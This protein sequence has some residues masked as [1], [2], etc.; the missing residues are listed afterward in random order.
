MYQAIYGGNAGCLAALGTTSCS[1]TTPRVIPAN[2]NASADTQVFL[3]QTWARPDMVFPHLSTVADANYPTVPDGRP[4][5][6]TSNPAFPNGFA[7]TLYYEAEGLAGMTADLRAAFAAKAQANPGFAGVIPVGDAF[8]RAVDQGVAQGDGFYGPDGT[9]AAALPQ[10][11]INL[12]WD[13]YLHASKHGS[14]L[15]ALVIFGRL[16]GIDPWS[17]GA[18]ERAAADLGI[19]PGDAVKLQRVASEQ[20]YAAGVALVRKPCLHSNPRSQGA[21]ACNGH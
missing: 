20:L 19:S 9:Y 18:S 2:P 4:I 5:V 14:Y 7:D 15:S 17:L 1:N 12:W 10:D 3:L 8:Q 21:R 16:T 6:D 11:R 13:D